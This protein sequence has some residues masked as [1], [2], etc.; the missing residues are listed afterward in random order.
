MRFGGQL[1]WARCNTGRSKWGLDRCSKI[2]IGNFSFQEAYNAWY[3]NNEAMDLSSASTLGLTLC[4]MARDEPQAFETDVLCARAGSRLKWLE[5]PE[6]IRNSR[7]ILQK[8]S[9]TFT[10]LCML[11]EEVVVHPHQ[12][13]LSITNQSIGMPVEGRCWREWKEFSKFLNRK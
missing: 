3:G 7:K 11:D 12:W 6:S 5:R 4:C 8:K 1:S 13:S 2:R 9:T 10:K